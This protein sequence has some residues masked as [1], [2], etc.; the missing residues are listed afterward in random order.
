M[1]NPHSNI[2]VLYFHNFLQKKKNK[3]I[4]LLYLKNFI[5]KKK[6]KK[7]HQVISR[8]QKL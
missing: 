6:K 5:K 4:T 8:G 2:T 7:K 3:K 1:Y